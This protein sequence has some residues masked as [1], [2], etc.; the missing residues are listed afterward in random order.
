[1]AWTYAGNPSA[2]PVDETHYRLGDVDGAN[3]IATDEECAFALCENN[4]NTYL[5]AAALAEAK[6]LTFVNRPTS[7]KRGD[8][9]T[10]Y[11]NGAEAYLMLARSLRLQASMQ[12]TTM[13]AGGQSVTEKRADR[14]DTTLVQPFATVD[15]HTPRPWRGWEDEERLG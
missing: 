5:A 7:I 4:G 12:T 14:L 3:P 11:G 13:Y 15:L 9:T 8:R 1:M 2:S 10:T 6:A